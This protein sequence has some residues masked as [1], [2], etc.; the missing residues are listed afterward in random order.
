MIRDG[1]DAE[2]CL[3]VAVD[4]YFH[5]IEAKLVASLPRVVP[6]K[7]NVLSTSEIWKFW[8]NCSETLNRIYYGKAKR[9]SGST[10]LEAA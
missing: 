2:K 8:M 4:Q 5:T 10:P 7:T 9:P 3:P 6:C 1:A